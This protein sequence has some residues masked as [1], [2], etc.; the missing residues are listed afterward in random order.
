MRIR[1]LLAA[2]AA[3]VL[4]L[5]GCGGKQVQ[6]NQTDGASPARPPKAG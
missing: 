2:T 1:G 3:A 6:D 4:V 5:S